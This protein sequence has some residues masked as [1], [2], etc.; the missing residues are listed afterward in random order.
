MSPDSAVQRFIRELLGR[1]DA[2]SQVGPSLHTLLQQ[3]WSERKVQDATVQDFLQRNPSV[4]RYESAFR[5]LWG[6]LKF[7]GINPPH[8]SLEE[9]ADSVIQIF[10]VSPAQA[11]NAYS[12]AL[13]IPSLSQ[14]RFVSLLNPYKRLWNLNVQ[15]YGHFYDAWPLL[16][17]L[18]AMSWEDLKR[19]LTALRLQFI[20]AARF[21]CLYRSHDLA[22]LKRSISVVSSCPFVKVKRKGQKFPHWEKMLSLPDWPQISPAHLL[23]EYVA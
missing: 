11:R 12:G 6:V 4:H 20:L 8:A 9:V 22:N 15:K 21:L 19:D 16:L 3:V 17:Q 23:Q 1:K 2:P 5:L 18:A 7:Q 10:Q 13:L 14:L